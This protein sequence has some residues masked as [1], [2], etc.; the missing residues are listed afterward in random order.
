MNKIKVGMVVVALLGASQAASAED[1]GM[2]TKDDLLVGGGIGYYEYNEPDI[3]LKLKAPVVTIL[4]E[5]TWKISNGDFIRLAA[6]YQYGK[7]DYSSSVSGTKNN[8]TNWIIGGRVVY[9]IDRQ[10]QNGVLSPYAGLGY[11]YLYNDMRGTSSTGAVGYQREESIYYLPIGL[12]YKTLWDSTAVSWNAEAGVVLDATQTTHFGDLGTPA[13][14]A[15][16]NVNFK[17]N[18]GYEIRLAAMAT[19]G[20]WEYGPYLEYWN[21]NKSE[22][23][24]QTILGVPVSAWEP[25]N[26]T[27]DIGI[28]VSRHF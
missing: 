9:G 22:T 23:K 21:I 11:R 2:L 18:A 13:G 8:N 26:D 5:K 16:G 24:T 20:V 17:Q 4:G 14:I 1:N 15:A 3:S 6:D 27:T 7:L 25:K 10:L 12:R 19:N 28:R